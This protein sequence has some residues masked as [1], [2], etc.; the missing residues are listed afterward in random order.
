MIVQ[1][2]DW[3]DLSDG[4]RLSVLQYA[5]C[6]TDKR[7]GQKHPQAGES[8]DSMFWIE[9]AVNA[10]RCRVRAWDRG[11]RQMFTIGD[12]VEDYRDLQ[13]L[14]SAAGHGN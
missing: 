8:V 3:R 7:W 2:V 5:A 10:D 1:G 6:E 14:K 9:R 4:E 12:A 13:K 11:L